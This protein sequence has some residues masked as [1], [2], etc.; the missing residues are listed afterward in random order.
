MTKDMFED[1]L[2][3]TNTDKEASRAAG[4]HQHHLPRLCLHHN[5]NKSD[6]TPHTQRTQPTLLPKNIAIHI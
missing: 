6:A 4:D 1:Q 5:H 3:N 2:R